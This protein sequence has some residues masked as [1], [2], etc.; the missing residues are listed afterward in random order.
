MNRKILAIFLCLSM[1]A[2]F[3]VGC[4]KQDSATTD[5]KPNDQVEKSEEKK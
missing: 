1:L 4:K 2:A 5:V 3:F